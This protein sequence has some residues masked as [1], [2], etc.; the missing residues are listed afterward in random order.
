M[1]DFIN[2][3]RFIHVIDCVKDTIITFTEAVGIF[4]SDELL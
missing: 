3:Y 4:G 2:D 1:S